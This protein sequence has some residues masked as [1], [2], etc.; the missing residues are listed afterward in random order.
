MRTEK[1]LHN[2]YLHGTSF[3][4][5]MTKFTLASSPL[6]DVCQNACIPS[7]AIDTVLYPA[8]DCQVKPEYTEQK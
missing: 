8:N 6:I 2:G 1:H 7:A 4:V 3:G 5:N